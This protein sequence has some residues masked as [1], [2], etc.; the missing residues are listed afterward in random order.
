MCL[1]SA[2]LN[3]IFVAGRNGRSPDLAI[4]YSK[5]AGLQFANF[6]VSFCFALAFGALIGFLLKKIN[7]LND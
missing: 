4:N 7:S 2:I 1:V 3:S 5:Q 6:I